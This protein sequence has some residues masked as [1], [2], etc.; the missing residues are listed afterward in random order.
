MFKE[1]D[2]TG[3]IFLTF[4]MH[5]L[6]SNLTHARFVVRNKSDESDTVKINHSRAQKQL[7]ILWESN[8]KNKT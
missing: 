1:V 5:N 6:I 8:S 4:S 7:K 3:V 2:V